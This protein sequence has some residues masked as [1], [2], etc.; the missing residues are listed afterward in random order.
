MPELSNAMMFV[1]VFAFE[2]FPGED[3]DVGGQVAC[4]ALTNS[5]AKP[6]FCEGVT[7]SCQIYSS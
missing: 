6:P 7:C 3:P 2:S 4:V 5:R 1:P